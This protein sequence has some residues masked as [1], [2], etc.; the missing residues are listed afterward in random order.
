MPLR[1]ARLTG[2]PILES[3]LNGTDKIFSGR[4]G[5]SV[6]RLQSALHDVGLSVGSAGTDGIFGSDTGAAVTTFKTSHG[7]VP[8]DPVVGPG[9]SRALDDDL[10]FD[11]A[12]LDPVFGEFS[13]AVVDHRLEQFVARELVALV[14][15]PLD[16]WRHMLG[17]FTADALNSGQV[18]G[19]TANS[20][21]IDLREP[22]LAVAD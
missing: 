15:A 9:T 5:L 2:D 14:L 13:P 12:V 19:I 17:R 6:M 4:D 3:C 1:A 11:P 22:F 7:L 10:F 21:G 20:R 8:N 18:L 16:S